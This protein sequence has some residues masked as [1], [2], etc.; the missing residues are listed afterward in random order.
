MWF[1]V[2]LSREGM[3]EFQENHAFGQRV[4]EE[5]ATIS[6]FSVHLLR[7]GVHELQETTIMTK[8]Y[9]GGCDEIA[10]RV[11]F[12]CSLSDDKQYTTFT[13]IFSTAFTKLFIFFSIYSIQWAALHGVYIAAV[14]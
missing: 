5:G 3:N 7:E 6:A 4:V 14:L 8:I 2:H 10:E 13:V 12:S 9:R 1:L 11:I